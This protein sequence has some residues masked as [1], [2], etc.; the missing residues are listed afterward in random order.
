MAGLNV[1][2]RPIADFCFAQMKL[3]VTGRSPQRPGR[4]PASASR[5]KREGPAMGPDV[6]IQ[7]QQEA[8]LTPAGSQRRRGNAAEMTGSAKENRSAKN[9]LARRIT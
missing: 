6:I 4:S 2:A 7:S 3:A 8:L 1:H 5:R 9:R